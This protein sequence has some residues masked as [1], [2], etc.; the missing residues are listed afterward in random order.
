MSR[1]WTSRDSRRSGRYPSKSFPRRASHSDPCSSSSGHWSA[2]PSR[3]SHSACGAAVADRT[4][5]PADLET[6][7][8]ESQ[9][10]R[11]RRNPVPSFPFPIVRATISPKVF[12]GPRLQ[13]EHAS[14]ER[15]RRTNRM[16]RAIL[17]ALVL[18]TVG[19][20]ASTPSRRTT[21]APAVLT[22]SAA[23]GAF[24]DYVLVIVM[25]NHNICDLLAS[26]GGTATYLSGLAGSYGVATKE[27][28]CHVNPSLPNY[29]CMTSGSDFGCTADPGP[30]STTCTK[31]AWGATNIVDRL[32]ADGLTWKGYMEDMPS[33]CY[34]TDSGNY[35]VHHN[36]F[37]YYSDIASDA[38]RCAR[39]VPAGPSIGSDAT[40]L[41]DLGSASTASNFMWLTPNKCND[42]HSC[43][44]HQGDTYM[45]GLVPKILDSTLFKTTLPRRLDSADR[46]VPARDRPRHRNP[47]GGRGDR[48]VPAAPP[49]ERDEG[50]PGE[51]GSIG[52]R[53]GQIADTRRR[54]RG[55]G[56]M[57]DL[58][59]SQEHHGHAFPSRV[60]RPC[61]DCD[62]TCRCGRGR[63]DR[64]ASLRR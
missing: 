29:L 12:T 50:V 47:G 20:A 58:T 40:L 30:N 61:R 44:I 10:E 6:G 22:G 46:P 21:P 31:T 4:R 52:A 57:G 8:G 1:P 16:I 23:P 56:R 26:C 35:V 54:R 27:M 55:R 62:R 28:Y 14:A 25:E 59:R 43:S 45:S 5:S 60:G 11:A 33:S 13:A 39:D 64:P 63:N 17:V 19:V 3:S 41:A 18:L 49:T 37:M 34:A 7:L 38:T 51:T 9:C 24:F 48:R 15:R 53:F 2:A 36:P 42:M 32:E